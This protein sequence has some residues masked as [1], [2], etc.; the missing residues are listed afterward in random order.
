MLTLLHVGKVFE[1]FHPH[2]IHYILRCTT[3]EER[4]DWMTLIRRSVE[5]IENEDKFLEVPSILL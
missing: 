5:T 1:L 3:I 2:P 4:N